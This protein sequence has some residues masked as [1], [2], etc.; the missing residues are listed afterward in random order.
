M[1]LFHQL[2]GLP[3]RGTATERAFLADFSSLF[4]FQPG[5]GLSTALSIPLLLAIKPKPAVRLRTPALTKTFL[6]SHGRER[7][8][9]APAV[10]LPCCRTFSVFLTL[11][12]LLT[13]HSRCFCRG[14]GRTAPQEAQVLATPLPPSVIFGVLIGRHRKRNDLALIACLHCATRHNIASPL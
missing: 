7:T 5:H 10:S 4:F 9:R 8:R 3:G 6:P 12:P 11:S 13:R 14:F 2:T 1:T